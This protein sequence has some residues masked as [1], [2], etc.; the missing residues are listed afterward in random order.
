MQAVN[1]P[2]NQAPVPDDGDEFAAIFD[3]PL[4]PNLEQSQLPMVEDLDEDPFIPLSRKISLSPLHDESVAASA[5]ELLYADLTEKTR[6]L[7][8][9]QKEAEEYK[10]KCNALKS[11]LSAAKKRQRPQAPPATPVPAVHPD[12]APKKRPSP[13]SDEPKADVA[14]DKPSANESDDEVPPP[15]PPALQPLAKE[16][17]RPFQLLGSILCGYKDEQV[18]PGSEELPFDLCAELCKE[19]AS[20]VSA[21][22]LPTCKR[23]HE[24]VLSALK[25]VYRKLVSLDIGFDR[26]IAPEYIMFSSLAS[27]VHL[28]AQKG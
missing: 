19:E 14:P 26:Y 8:L 22:D 5:S 17:A 11:S 12:A 13:S 20:E 10:M 24:A 9:A 3:S 6:L 1:A 7:E 15:E 16:R 23:M 21:W 28:S 2:K 4:G 25:L 18:T 27:Y